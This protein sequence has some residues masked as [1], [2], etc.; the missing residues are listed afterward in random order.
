MVLSS[1]GN[2]VEPPGSS[3]STGTEVGLTMI[4][5]VSDYLLYLP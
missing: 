3:C 2:W 4:M 5:A 1:S